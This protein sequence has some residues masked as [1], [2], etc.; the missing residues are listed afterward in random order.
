MKEHRGKKSW[1]QLTGRQKL[2]I[3]VYAAGQLALL[4]AALTDLKKRP[5]E[6]VNGS[7]GAW[8]A[9]CFVNYL[10]PAAYFVFGRKK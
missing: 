10:G 2:S 9:A 8:A 4:A 1:R 3:L 6:Q 5:P 7:K